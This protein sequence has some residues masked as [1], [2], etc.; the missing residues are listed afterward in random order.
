[1]DKLNII[2][3]GF[4]IICLI[5]LIAT[6]ILN[7]P[8][9]TMRDTGEEI[10]ER[11]EQ[12]TQETTAS[13]YE[14]TENDIFEC[15]LPHLKIEGNEVNTFCETEN[16]ETTKTQNGWQYKGC[17]Y[18]ENR[19]IKNHITCRVNYQKN[20]TEFWRGNCSVSCSIDKEVVEKDYRI[21]KEEDISYAGCKRVG[22]S[23]VIPNNTTKKRARAI[24]KELIDIYFKEE[25]WMDVTIW[26][27]NDEARIGKWPADLIEEFSICN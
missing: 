1:M 13:K 5:I 17:I 15:V 11:N 14:P 26:A 18:S 22:V 3:G 10:S 24:V 23:T 25:G 19:T 9:E 20:D 21:V 4:G 2:F 6:L 7:T 12:A 27:Y 16:S 8:T